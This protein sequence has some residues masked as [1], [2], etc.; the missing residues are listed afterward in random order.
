MIAPHSSRPRR[1]PAQL[2]HVF[3][4]LAAVV[5]FSTVARHA[6]GQEPRIRVG[7][8][9]PVEAQQ[10][11]EAEVEAEPSKSTVRG[12]AVFEGTGRPARRARV[13]L[14]EERAAPNA[15]TSSTGLTNARG[16]F[17]V[18][19]VKAGRYLVAVA[20][21]GA[22]TPYSFITPGE[23]TSAT[24]DFA[25]ARKYFD[26]VVVDGVGDAEVSVK[27]RRGGAISGRVTYEDGA[28]AVSATV[29]LYRRKA[30]QFV[31]M[32]AAGQADDRGVYRFTSLAPGEY[33]VG[34][35]EPVVHGG[36]GTDEALAKANA[37][38]Y[39][40][41]G[42]LISTFYPAATTLGASTPLRVEAGQERDGVDIA[43]IERE[44]HTLSGVVRARTGN[45]PVAGAHVNISAKD[46]PPGVA[47]YAAV[48]PDAKT[49]EHGR[50]FLKEI[51]DGDYVITID[52]SADM[53]ATEVLTPAQPRARKPD[54]LH[55]VE[56]EVEEEPVYR[57][58]LQRYPS[59]RQELKVAGQDVDNFDI[60]LGDGAFVTGTLSV[61]G[62]KPLPSYAGVS[63]VKVGGDEESKEGMYWQGQFAVGG[64]SA[65]RHYI[66]VTANGEEGEYYVKSMTY[67]G[68][69]LT[70]EPLRVEDGATLRGVRI[71]LSSG[72]ATLKGSVVTAGER[73]PAGDAHVAIVSADAAKWRLPG[74]Q[75]HEFAELSGKFV[76]DLPPGDYL[77]FAFPPG[78]PDSLTE[79][80]LKSY[81][82]RAQRVSLR[83]GQIA[84]VELTAAPDR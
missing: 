4:L 3:F 2:A 1:T 19:R 79:D 48:L 84:S 12:R 30:G 66:S 54:R 31:R 36:E 25:E 13:M 46:A 27:A 32:A 72:T 70:R 24:P 17:E 57:A 15:G 34:V 23:S 62:G 5:C 9:I 51:P 21:P 29:V 67:N 59:K 76:L 52:P 16:E 33:C 38:A 40:G 65:G 80:E 22:L 35:S 20:A 14:L 45:K 49:D 58:P 50:W 55:G 39:G 53:D 77:I 18:R 28:P 37:V 11:D 78:K 61:E 82:Q 26:E 43:V 68:T 64:L 47:G 44:L 75:R 7:E 74:S 42:S 8:K 63:T 10:S 73:A 6:R 60:V 83:P 69:D 71:V 56:I 41:G 81:A